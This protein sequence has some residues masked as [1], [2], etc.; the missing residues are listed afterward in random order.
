M[1]S[2]EHEIR[3]KIAVL[4]LQ[5]IAFALLFA[6]VLNFGMGAG[7]TIC[8]ASQSA[9]ALCLERP[10][11]ADACP[12]CLVKGSCSSQRSAPTSNLAEPLAKA[13][14]LSALTTLLAFVA[15]A[16]LPLLWRLF[17][18]SSEGLLARS[19]DLPSYLLRPP[20]IFII[21]RSLLI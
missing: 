9:C 8:D 5:K 18:A 15:C 7:A 13:I 14:A 21:Y 17:A 1:I 19:R 11:S 6:F 16:R 12:C 2:D 10:S 20:R 3:V 4:D